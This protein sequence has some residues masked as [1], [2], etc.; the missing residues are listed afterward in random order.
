MPSQCIFRN[1]LWTINCKDSSHAIGRTVGSILSAVASIATILGLFLALHDRREITSPVEAAFT[2]TPVPGGKADTPTIDGTPQVDTLESTPDSP[3][4]SKKKTSSRLPQPRPPEP[5]YE[6]TL[7]DNG[8]TVILS[9][10]ASVGV[11]FNKIGEEQFLTVHINTGTASRSE[12]VFGGGVRL[13]L[14]LGNTEYA[15]SI[16]GIDYSEKTAHVRVDRIGAN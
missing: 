14:Q 1:F 11:Q 12:A 7:R 3:V 2:P 8:Q 4:Q 13:P 5:T 15:I 6:F 9:G 10:Q 16:L